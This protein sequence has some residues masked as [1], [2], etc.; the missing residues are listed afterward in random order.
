MVR[1]AWRAIVPGL[2]RVGH[3]RATNTQ[4]HVKIYIVN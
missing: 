2:Q 1:E 3:D 4:Q